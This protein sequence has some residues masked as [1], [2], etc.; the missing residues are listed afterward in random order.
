MEEDSAS[1]S[2]SAGV[3]NAV[4]VSSPCSE[5]VEYPSLKCRLFYLP[6]EFTVLYVVA[7]YIPLSANVSIWYSGSYMTTIC[8]L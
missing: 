3:L 7:V 8:E 1:A 5:S 2:T 4:P 6:R